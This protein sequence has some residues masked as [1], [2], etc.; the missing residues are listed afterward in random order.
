MCC[1]ELGKGATS[2]VGKYLFRAANVWWKRAQ[3]FVLGARCLETICE[4]CLQNPQNEMVVIFESIL[5]NYSK[6]L[7]LNNDCSTN[8]LI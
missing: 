1:S 3:Y 8:N 7:P 5:I 6:P 4:A 2:N